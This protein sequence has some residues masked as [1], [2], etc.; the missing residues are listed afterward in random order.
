MTASDAPSLAAVALEVADAHELAAGLTDALSDAGLAPETHDVPGV[1]EARRFVAPGGLTVDLVRGMAA[2]EPAR[3][4]D[5]ASTPRK[6]GHAPPTLTSDVPD[7]ARGGAHRAAGI[8]SLRHRP[9][10]LSWYRCSADHHGI[11]IAP[12]PSAGC[13]TTRSSSTGGQSSECSPTTSR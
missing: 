1:A 11:A 2:D 9:R 13:T 6:F 5:P 4:A 10:V 8:S 12:P 7:A 3:F